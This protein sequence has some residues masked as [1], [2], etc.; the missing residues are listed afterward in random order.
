MSASARSDLFTLWRQVQP[1]R[2]RQLLLVALLMPITAIAE[3]AMIGSLIPFLTLL[4]GQPSR[5]YDVDWLNALER[6][7]T[8]AAGSQLMAAAIL[9]IIAAIITAALRLILA[10]Q[11]ERFA[12]GLGHELALEVQRRLLYQPYLP[13]VYL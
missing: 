13:L 1:H 5:S 2:K 10:W 11:S 3:L 12:Y 4:A 8:T 9:F 7:A 6:W